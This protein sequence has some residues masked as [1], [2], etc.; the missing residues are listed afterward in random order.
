MSDEEIK[1]HAI[2]F[3]KHLIRAFVVDDLRDHWDGYE[4]NEED[5]D[6]VI[7]TAEEVVSIIAPKETYYGPGQQ[8]AED[9]FSARNDGD[10]E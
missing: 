3:A 9:F 5:W 2:E 7:K 10:E 6:L 1:L 4:I 8:E